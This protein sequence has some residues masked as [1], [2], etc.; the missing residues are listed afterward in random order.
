MEFC[1]QATC[2]QTLPHFQNIYAIELI[3]QKVNDLTGKN[4]TLFFVFFAYN[5]NKV[6]ASLQ[7]TN[8]GLTKP[9]LYFPQIKFYYSAATPV[10]F[11]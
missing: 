6:T 11:A 7:G 1:F 3:I 9:N 4:S 10:S 5:I 2:R 8:Y